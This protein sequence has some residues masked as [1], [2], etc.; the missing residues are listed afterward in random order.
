M[1]SPTRQTS[2]CSVYT[3]LTSDSPVILSSSNAPNAP[4]TERGRATRQALLDAAAEVFGEE[5]YEGAS[6][7]EITRRAGVAQGTFYVHFPEKSAT[8]SE[9][10]GHV[11]HKIRANSAAAVDGI[12]NRIDVERRGF[13][14][15]F[16]YVEDH[17]GIY[18]I[19]RDAEFAAPEAHRE[20][21]ATLA[22]GYAEGLSAAMDD[23]QIAK[24][25]DPELLAYILMGIGEFLG[26]RLDDWSDRLSRD[27]VF[28]QLMRFVARGLGAQGASS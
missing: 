3:E 26:L 24:D 19:I 4:V 8:F 27:E 15:F 10:V 12:D 6:V 9:L 17:P 21:Y 11:N 2:G 22:K 14:A 5:G 1:W 16:E 18:R 13:K 23:G 7:A 28:E 25:V 20:H